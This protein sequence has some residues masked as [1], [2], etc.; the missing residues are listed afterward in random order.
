VNQDIDKYDILLSLLQENKQDL[1]SLR[2]SNHDIRDHM[3]ALSGTLNLLSQSH[4][5]KQEQDNQRFEYLHTR[6]DKEQEVTEKK[7]Q[8]IEVKLNDI[9]PK[10]SHMNKIFDWATRIV[11]TALVGAVLW[12]LVQYGTVK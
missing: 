7:L 11:V 1:K 8:L 9:A 4:N 5:V 6:I 12:A 10:V 3:A 2:D